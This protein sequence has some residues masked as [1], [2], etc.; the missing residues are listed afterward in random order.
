[1]TDNIGLE[2]EHEFDVYPK[3]GIVLVKGKNAKVWDDKGK[4]YIDCVAGHGVVNIGHCNDKVVEAIHE[5]AQKLITCSGIFYNDARALLYKKLVEISPDNLKSSFL[6]NSG[7]EAVEAAI[8]FAR[9]TTKKTDFIC[10][11]RGFHGR[12]FGALSATAN[13]KYRDDF[14]PLVPGF[15]HVPFNNFEKLKEKVNENTAGILIEIVQGEGGVHVGD[16]E[17]FKQ[18]RELCDEKGV[19][20]IIDEVQS[21]FCRTGKMFACQHMELEPDILCIAKSIAGG[22]PMGAVLC[23]DKVE[24]PK[25]KHGT[26]FGGN[27]LAC[28]AANA[29]IDFMLENKLDKQAEEKGKYL[30]NKLRE[31]GID[32]LEKVREVRHLGLFLGIELKEKS[33]EY[34]EKLMELGVLALPAGATVIR[35]LP[36]LTIS[37]EGL[38]FVIDKLIKVLR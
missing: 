23:S 30:F 4:E 28:A 9:Y 21:G 1:M 35:L 13:P 11:M 7:A 16:K 19:M 32:K 20:L 5:Q 31:A 8:K 22:I 6:C 15:A 33:R 12:T 18:V 36:P 3:R 17:Y 2:E 25:Q 27:P 37:Y 38:D 24:V 34:I 26:T 10:A 14:K 29:A